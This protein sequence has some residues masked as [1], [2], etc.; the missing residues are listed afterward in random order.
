MQIEDRR[1]IDYQSVQMIVSE[2]QISLKSLVD[3][4][5]ERKWLINKE[6]N[7]QGKDIMFNASWDN[8]NR[9]KILSSPIVDEVSMKNFAETLY[10][11]L[12]DDTRIKRGRSIILSKKASDKYT[13][14]ELYYE[15]FANLV[16]AF[17]CQFTHSKENMKGAKIQPKDVY[18]RYIEKNKPPQ[19][20]DEYKKLQKGLLSDY[21]S[22]LEAILKKI[23][24]DNSYFGIIE[25]SEGI[26]HTQ[27]ISLTKNL[28]RFVGC[29]CYITNTVPNNNPITQNQY[30]FF[31]PSPEYINCNVVGEATKDD[32][33]GVC[34][35]G[36]IKLDSFAENRVGKGV[37]VLRV[38]TIDPVKNQGYSFE[39]LMIENVTLIRERKE[40]EESN[41][42]QSV[43][44]GALCTVELDEQSRTHV[45]NILIS[46]KYRC[47]KGQIVKLNK[48]IVNISNNKMDY[49]YVAAEVERITNTTIQPNTPYVVEMDKDGVMHVGNVYID[50]RQSLRCGYWVS[51]ESIEKNNNQ[52]LSK[53]YPK[54][55]VVKMVV[56]TDAE[57][58]GTNSKK[59]SIFK[60]LFKFIGIT[61]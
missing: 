11:S 44:E 19:T 9:D 27:H 42:Q 15:S 30:P 8:Y 51:F 38:R 41:Q 35:T 59:E 55:G 10:I 31:C 48:I 28:F 5:N 25:V 7:D 4:I 58:S 2:Y 52:K 6:L 61:K 45:G 24:S 36:G 34:S 37:R 46:T 22:F 54:K 32:I 3:S 50:S 26:V 13:L 33:T 39:A 56:K 40:I 16:S 12:F 60:R 49:P 17:R 20:E 18:L 57:K 43:E 23:Q 29:E 21:V 47:K 53:K 14:G 1:T